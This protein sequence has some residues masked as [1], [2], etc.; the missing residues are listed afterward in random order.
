MTPSQTRLLAAVG[1]N[2]SDLR[3]TNLHKAWT[4]SGAKLADSDTPVILVEKGPT[5]VAQVKSAICKFQACLVLVGPLT[6]TLILKV[7]NIADATRLVTEA[8]LERAVAILRSCEFAAATTKFRTLK[9]LEC[10]IAKLQTA[11]KDFDNR[12]LFENHYLRERVWKDTRTDV[13][14]VA[15][16]VVAGKDVWGVL[17]ALGW[18][19][20]TEYGTQRIDDAVSITVVSSEDLSTRKTDHEVAPSYLAVDALKNSTWSILTNGREWRLYSAR[21]SAS[22]TNYF[23]VVLDPDQKHT[24]RYLSVMFDSSSYAVIDGLRDID[25]FFEKSRDYARGLEDDLS[26]RIMSADGP[27][28]HIVKGI[29]DHDKKKSFSSEELERGRRA[30]LAVMYRIWFVL[31]AESR[32]LLPT[33]DEKYK[34]IS[35]Q[36]LRV[37]LEEY[38]SRPTDVDCWARLLQLF[39]G[40]RRGSKTHNLP[41]YDGDLFKIMPQID[42]VQVKNAHTVAAL[43]GLLERDGSAVDYASLNVRHLGSVYETLMEYKV[44]QAKRDIMLIEKHGKIREIS[45]KQ[46]GAYSYKKNDLYLISGGGIAL[47]K[48]TASYYTPDEMVKF[49]VRR[50]LDPI[51]DEREALLAADM[52]AYSKDPSNANRRTCMDRLLDIQV[53]DPAM[54]SG[55][56]LV[57][58]LSRITEWATGMLKEHPKHPLLAEIDI[59][60]KT[61]V[62]E[63]RRQGVTIDRSRLTDDV[64]L[65]RRVMKRCIFGV[66]LNPLA[67]DLCKLSLWLDSFAIGVPLTYLNHHIKHGDSTIGM[68]RADMASKH[69]MALDDYVG[70]TQKAGDIMSDISY[71]ADVTVDAVRSSEDAHSEYEKR[72]APHKMALDALTAFAIDGNLLQK[73]RPKMLAKLISQMSDGSTNLDAQTRRVRD[74]VRDLSDRYSFFHW[75]LEMMDAFTD[76]RWGFDCI[77]GNFPWEK[78]KADDKEFF[79][80]HAPS[81]AFMKTTPEKEKLKKRIFRENPELEKEYDDYKQTFVDKGAFYKTFKMQGTGDRD[82]WQLMLERVV[83]LASAQ[84]LRRL[85]SENGTISVL[86]PSGLLTGKSAV[87]MRRRLL[88]MDIQQMYVFEN[89]GIFPIHSSYR[90]LLMTVRHRSG[91][92]EFPVGF[93]LHNLRSL[94]DPSIEKDKFSSMSKTRI[95]STFP[96]DLIIPEVTRGA[97][98][99]LETASTHNVLASGLAEGWDVEI[100]RGLDRSNDSNL[101]RID[102]KGWP[103]VEGKYMHQFNHAY[104]KP[105]F[106]IP[107]SLGLKKLASKKIYRR[108]PSNFYDSYQLVFRNISH[109]RNMRT[110]MAAILPP[111]T[112]YTHSLSVVIPTYRGA[113]KLGSE[114]NRN[115]AYLAGLLNSMTFD[116]L[117]RSKV[118]TNVASVIKNT[119]IPRV[120]NPKI[121]AL[122]AKLSVGAD[123]FEQF[124]E[125]LRISNSYLSLSD[126]LHACAE[127]DAMVAHAYGLTRDEYLTVLDSFQFDEA[128]YLHEADYADL[129]D[130]KVLK[131]FYGEVRK[132]AP[133]YY[134]KMTGGEEA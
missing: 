21:M 86:I 35:L 93:Y 62:E 120:P 61:V 131:K 49:L 129:S 91:P 96:D 5:T 26:S 39:N 107:P 132:L 68:W 55:H 104:S 119:P 2:P 117:I 13:D 99:I 92:D 8:D 100:T 16:R 34:P 20:R 90:L 101:F 29:L 69:N 46:P 47:R 22:T 19:M 127:L 98:S 36:T 103:V 31:Y 89:K 67:V 73:Q 65:K 75:E 1:I 133:V 95:R 30:A 84:Q 109:G 114:Y 134:D 77:V 85:V 24:A 128:P 105:R 3:E 76:G 108:R 51:L 43:K 12:G 60:R 102:G 124:A 63:Q 4:S 113:A 44:K 7:G 78:S 9:S 125:S 23:S 56:F 122:A 48:S 74:K 27:F 28:L 126:R 54:G 57:E 17:K 42:N 53:L 37:R 18:Q 11:T 110:V 72:V 33:N 14:D 32:D 10:T 115:I 82:M 66:D 45:A 112:F 79:A 50:G 15:E 81:F 116:F 80:P 40:I 6:D 118:N 41:Q 97:A 88:D 123:T 38:E 71:S 83:G 111:H 106:T 70:E 94:E 58:A 25:T 59:D 87:E 121:T 64:L 130:N 52:K